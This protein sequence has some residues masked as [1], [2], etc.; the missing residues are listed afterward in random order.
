MKRNVL[1]PAL[2]L[3]LLATMIPVFAGPMVLDGQLTQTRVSGL[4]SEIKWNTSLG[5]ALD[6]ARRE[7][8]M[9]FWV[10]ML[11]SMNGTT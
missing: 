1:A 4:N 7:G 6:T 9:V 5:Q 2:S 8:K 3:A 11:G 10:H